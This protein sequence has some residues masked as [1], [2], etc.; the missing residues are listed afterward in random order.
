[1]SGRIYAIGDIHGQCDKLVAAH[2]A[3]AADA[4]REGGGGPRVVHIGDLCDRGPDT[5]GVIDV[6]LAG[7]E[8]GEDWIVLKG[9]HD[10]M[11]AGWMR[12]KDHRDPL[13]REGLDWLAPN[14][15][16]TAT[17]AS[18][19]VERRLMESKTSLHRRAAKAVPERHI[20]FAEGLPLIYREGGLFFCHAGVR[21]GVPLDEQIEDDL[22]WIRSGF[23]E[24]V[25]DHGALI[26]HGH[27]A[28]DAPEHYGNRVNLD[29]GAG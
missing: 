12:A 15:G 1:M 11:F 3:I 23:L 28:L 26:V 8:R 10:R 25:R 20:E 2:E 18:Y 14:L 24:D 29:G 4:A 13:L 6:L 5:R 17:L 22:L 19:G 27:T 16:G 21:P 7:I 9:N